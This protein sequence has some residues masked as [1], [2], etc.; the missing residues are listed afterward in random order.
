MSS[1]EVGKKFGSFMIRAYRKSRGVIPGLKFCRYTPTCSQYTLEAILKYGLFR[2][3][4]L[5]LKRL[6]R[7]HPGHPGGH[8][9]VP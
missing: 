8:D 1:R 3:S 5:G 7:C 6:C 2:G 4:W 9:P